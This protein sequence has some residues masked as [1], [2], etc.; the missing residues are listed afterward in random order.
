[1]AIF[2]LNEPA[3]SV[4][5]SSGNSADCLAVAGYDNSGHLSGDVAADCLPVAVCEILVMYLVAVTLIVLLIMLRMIMPREIIAGSWLCSIKSKTCDEV[6]DVSVISEEKLVPGILLEVVDEEGTLENV[7][8]ELILYQKPC[9]EY[10]VVYNKLDGSVACCC[11]LFVRCVI[12]CRYIFC[13]FKNS[14]VLKIPD[15][16]ILKR[17]T[18]DLIPADL[19]RQKARYGQENEEIEKLAI[20]AS[21]L[22]EISAETEGVVAGGS[23]GD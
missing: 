12:L 1:M 21:S 17:W 7:E 10:K 18:R 15:Q 9:G 22:V 3:I 6:C 8:E 4:S 2:D 20:E 19:R 11:Q 5:K 16:Y 23:G 13:V 14:N